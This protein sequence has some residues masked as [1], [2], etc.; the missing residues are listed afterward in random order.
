MEINERE[1]ENPELNEWTIIAQ[2][3][4]PFHWYVNSLISSIPRLFLPI[5][6][7]YRRMFHDGRENLPVVKYCSKPL[8]TILK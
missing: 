1:K 4:Y 2:S 8:G 7:I 3:T 5:K 6:N